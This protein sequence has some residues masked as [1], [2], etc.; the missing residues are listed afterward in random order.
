MKFKVL[1]LAFL[2]LVFGVSGALADIVLFDWA[3]N[4]NGTTYE[5]F[6]GDSMPTTGSLIGGLGTLSW[7]TN[8]AGSKTFIAFFDHELSESVN[9]FHN[10][11]G[12]TTGSLAAGQSWEIDEPGWVFG[13]IYN[14]VRGGV[15]DNLNA[16][17]VAFPDDVSMAMGWD[18][19]L[20]PG[21]I[22]TIALILSQT[23]P[24][25]GFYLQQTDFDTG[26]NIYF[27]STLTIRDGGGPAVPEPAT[28][29]LLGSGL[30]GLA[31]LGRRKL[32]K[33]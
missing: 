29:L 17:P 4:V 6:N 3:F 15:L 14:H 2:F 26:E 16:V 18:F 8:T 19:T 24:G 7:T 13:D 30:V 22:A 25:S 27:S 1:A 21:K 11:Y 10:E 31:G 28:M 12:A 33:K 5:N 23:P 9:G 32:F 20:D